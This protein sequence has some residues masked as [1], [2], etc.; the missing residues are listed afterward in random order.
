[1]ELT[2]ADPLRHFIAFGSTAAASAAWVR[3][4]IA[5]RTRCSAN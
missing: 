4:T 1:M 3:P 5:W 2:A